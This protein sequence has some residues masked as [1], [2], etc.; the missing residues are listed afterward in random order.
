MKKSKRKRILPQR[1]KPPLQGLS[2]QYMMQA[3][4]KLDALDDLPHAA[5]ALVYEYGFDRA[6]LVLRQYY[7]RWAE[8]RR[9]LEAERQLLQEQRWRNIK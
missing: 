4:M 7:G 3:N 1:P 8:A 6:F 5:R 9:V 2:V